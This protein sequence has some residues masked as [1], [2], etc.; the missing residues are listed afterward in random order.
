MAGLDL[1]PGRD[2]VRDHSKP[3]LQ[4]IH[5]RD[6]ADSVAIVHRVIGRHLDGR[7]PPTPRA[8]VVTW[9]NQFAARP[10]G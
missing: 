2:W 9:F 1:P 7:D 6:A 3:L 5:P 10:R 4:P 8:A